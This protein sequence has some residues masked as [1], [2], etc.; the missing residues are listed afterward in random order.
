MSSFVS[1]GDES[2]SKR[3]SRQK[4]TRGKLSR[5]SINKANLNR[6]Q[7]KGN[8]KKPHPPSSPPPERTSMSKQNTHKKY[9]E[10]ESSNNYQ[11]H[12]D[13]FNT[14][15]PSQWTHTTSH[16]RFLS[17]LLQTLQVTVVHP[18][19]HFS[20]QRVKIPEIAWKY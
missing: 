5:Y 3:R 10:P 1:D 7:A 12:Q 4:S 19:P 11:L 13:S 9:N 18:T 6:K 16:S 2:R 20:R 17:S 14:L 8:R 15:V